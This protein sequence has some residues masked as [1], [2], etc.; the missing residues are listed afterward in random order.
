MS[1]APL[2]MLHLKQRFVGSAVSCYWLSTLLLS[3]LMPCF[4]VVFAGYLLSRTFQAFKRIR[5][6][7]I[8]TLHRLSRLATQVQ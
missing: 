2:M 5:G 4:L 3:V 1:V 7:R 8:L 6:W